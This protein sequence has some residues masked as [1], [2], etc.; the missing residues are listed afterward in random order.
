M[1]LRGLPEGAAAITADGRSR[2]PPAPASTALRT[3]LYTELHVEGRELL[4]SE[5]NPYLKL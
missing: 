1:L 4:K 2:R 5:Q 3:L